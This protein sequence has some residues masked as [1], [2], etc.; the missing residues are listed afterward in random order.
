MLDRALEA[1]IDL[2]CV[3]DRQSIAGAVRLDGMRPDG[4]EIAIGCEFD[5][6]DGSQVIG[7]GLEDVIAEK[8]IPHLLGAI[9]GSGG[10]VLLPHPFRRGGGIFSAARKRSPS[11]VEEVLALTDAV[12]CFIGRDSATH[13]ALNYGLAIQRGLTSVAGRDAH[14]SSEIGSVFVE[15]ETGDSPPDVSPRRIFYP[16]Q[17]AVSGS[18]ARRRMMNLYHSLEPYLPSVVGSSYRQL[19]RRAGLDRARTSGS[20]AR[21]QHELDRTPQ[22]PE[23][24][25]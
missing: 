4:I 8:R 25:V 11:F 1:G 6:E 14:A 9:R 5:T 10:T 7:L 15:Y 13:N 21:M 12:E 20:P 19:R 2:P 3:T 22:A 17:P 23:D 16:D 18:A 24:E